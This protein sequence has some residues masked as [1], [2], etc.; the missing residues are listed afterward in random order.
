V[1][2]VK[3]GDKEYVRVFGRDKKGK[4]NKI[5]RW[6]MLKSDIEGLTPEQIKD[7]FAL[8]FMPTHICDVKP[9]SDFVLQA[10]IANELKWGKGGDYSLQ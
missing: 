8:S 3:A 5:G 4:L 9:S 10:S 7:K 1:K 6:I 2:N